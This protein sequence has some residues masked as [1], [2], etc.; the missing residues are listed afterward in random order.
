MGTTQD[1][2]LTRARKL[3]ERAIV[4]DTHCDTTQRLADHDW[5]FIQRHGSGHVDLPRLREGGVDAA[6]FAVWAKA[7]VVAGEGIKTARE[8]ILRIH[9]LVE[10]HGAQLALCR[11][12]D[13]VRQAGTKGQFALLVAIEGGYLIEDS[14]DV[15]GD[16]HQ[17]GATY[18]TLTH[19]FHTSWADS[20]GIDE[21]LTP[22]HGGLAPFGREVVAELNR[23][24]MMVDVSHAGDDTVRDVIET[25][26][27]PVIA[28][29]SSCRSVSG[30]RRNLSDELMTAIADAGGVIQINFAA[31]FIDPNFPQ[32]APE[33][34]QR[35]MD[36]GFPSGKMS[37][38]V[39]PLSVLADHFDHALEIVGPDHV[40]IGSDFDGVPQ[41]PVGMEDCSKLPHLTAEL[42]RR[43]HAED[44]L[45]KVLGAN[46]L[47]VMEACEKV[48]RPKRGQS[49]VD[50]STSPGPTHE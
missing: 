24:G 47:R 1:E 23:L 9:R 4:I 27:A 36:A 29:H 25:S 11:S 22:R 15:L 6:F 33:V 12:A 43:G 21:P 10:H 39:T 41:L 45:V 7:P 42:L 37:D 40:G 30:H 5:D 38:H 35:W 26:T 48:A 44:V 34:F 3:H 50:E 17:L 28:T 18:L 20:S 13:E 49:N 2:F 8:Q 14:L 32:I 19:A 46:T 16:Y 31:N